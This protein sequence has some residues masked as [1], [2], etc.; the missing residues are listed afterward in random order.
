MRTFITGVLAPLLLL[1]CV[2]CRSETAGT[3]AETEAAVETDAEGPFGSE[4][5][6]NEDSTSPSIRVLTELPEG[7]WTP[8]DESRMDVLTS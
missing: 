1:F 5:S 2:S 3:P 4:P 6:E 8:L 7:Y